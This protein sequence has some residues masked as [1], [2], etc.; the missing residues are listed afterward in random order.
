MIHPNCPRSSAC[1]T[2]GCLEWNHQIYH[3]IN[4]S[5]ANT[6]VQISTRTRH[7]QRPSSSER[8]GGRQKILPALTLWTAAATSSHSK[9]YPR[10]HNDSLDTNYRPFICCRDGWTCARHAV[11][12]D[13]GPPYQQARLMYPRPF[14]CREIKIHGNRH[15]STHPVRRWAETEDTIPVQRK[16]RHQIL[17]RPSAVAWPCRKGC[18]GG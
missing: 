6:P 11:C 2:C 7:L 14:R 8:H 18:S 10:W 17:R 1:R 12:S 15:P 3:W 13:N 4:C 16:L 9:S 5:C